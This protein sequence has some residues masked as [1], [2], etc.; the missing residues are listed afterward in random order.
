[1][2]LLDAAVVLMVIGAAL[3]GAGYYRSH[4]RQTPKGRSAVRRGQGSRNAE[5]ARAE[6]ELKC[7]E[8]GKPVNSEEDVYAHGA[9]WHR[10]CYIENVRSE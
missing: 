8:C 2:I 4:R 9:W 10:D 3:V 7:L 5:E 1:M 6:L